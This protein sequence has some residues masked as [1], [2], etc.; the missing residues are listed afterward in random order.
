MATSRWQQKPKRSTKPELAG[1]SAA[2]ESAVDESVAGELVRVESVPVEAAG[3][4]LL[5]GASSPR[6]ATERSSPPAAG[7]ELPQPRRSS[8]RNTALD[9]LA[10]REHSIA[11]LRAK[12]AA[13]AADRGWSPAEIETTLHALVVDGLL[14]EDRFLESFVGSH[15]RRGRGPVWIR[16]ELEHRGISG[17]VIATALT[18]IDLNWR[19][20]ATEVRTRK[21][22]NAPPA[23]FQARAKQARFLQYRG[24]TADQVRAALGTDHD[25]QA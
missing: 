25:D 10:R 11:E 3:G 14:S 18:S 2:L 17:E 24:F 23:D 7:D 1:E 20:V 19:Q 9:I 4:E 8:P 22:G 5:S 6:A 15:A 21:F 13:R 16:A 12:L